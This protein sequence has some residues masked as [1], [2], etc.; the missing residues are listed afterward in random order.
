MFITKEILEK[1]YF[2][3]NL[4]QDEIGEKYKVSGRNIS[5]YFKKFNIK[6]NAAHKNELNI[7][8]DILER[9]Y[10]N[11]DLKISDISK[12]L[13][14][15]EQTILKYIHKYNINIKGAKYYNTLPK[16]N[17][18][19]NQYEFFDGLILSDGSLVRR[20]EKNGKFSNAKISCGF[21][22][23]EFAEYID[24]YLELDGNIHKKIHKSSRYKSGEC[25]QYG[26]MSKDNILFSE[27]RNRW[28]PNNI[29]EIPKDFRFSPISMNIAYIGDGHLNKKNKYILISTQAFKK[30]D[31]ENTIINNLHNNG[32]KCW[33]TKDN[34]IYVP[35]NETSNF[36]SFIGN[37]QVEC[38]KYKWQL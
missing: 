13:N 12:I 10:I 14:I 5:Y 26:L 24:K 35:K 9:L 25:I 32:I 16:I 2:D 27:E 7:D 11:K 8:K 18:S 37:C 38:Y 20:K 3:E 33:L 22:Y 29:K 28:Y 6:A 15:S 4:T 36:L 23:K 1:L 34:N 21:K 17:F 31:I 30:I 19:N